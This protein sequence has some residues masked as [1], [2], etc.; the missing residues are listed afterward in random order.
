M[1][2]KKRRS[3]NPK[4]RM[5]E[6]PTSKAEAS[7]LEILASRVTYAGNPAHK[8]KPGDF[9]LSPPSQPREGKIL[10]DA[11]GIAKRSIA[12][13]L[14][15][16]GLLR[17]MIRV[18]ERKGWPQNIWA[19]HGDDVP[20]EAVLENSETGTYHG[21]PLQRDD[22]FAGEVVARWEQE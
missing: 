19:V 13:A 4:R 15:K 10:C 1:T 17:G 22:P 18:Q 7:S 14:L 3:G 6:A 21:Y 20:M 11:A 12:T 9:G 8:K 2:M 16:Q 5:R